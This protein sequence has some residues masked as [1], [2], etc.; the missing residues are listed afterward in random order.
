MSSVSS[1]VSEFDTAS[2]KRHTREHSHFS[3]RHL[4]VP[5]PWSHVAKLRLP[6]ILQSQRPRQGLRQALQ[7]GARGWGH[8]GRMGRRPRGLSGFPAG[9]LVGIGRGRPQHKGPPSDPAPA[10]GAVGSTVGPAWGP[11]TA[12]P[13]LAHLGGNQDTQGTVRARREPRGTAMGR[14]WT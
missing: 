6:G 1:G 13:A 8:A 7:V 5:Q 4:G 12:K 9:V 3:H 2:L 14:E 11:V 10:S